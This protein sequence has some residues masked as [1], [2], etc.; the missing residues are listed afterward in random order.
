MAEPVQSITRV[1]AQ[2]E[3]GVHI[4]QCASREYGV[5][6]EPRAVCVQTCASGQATLKLVCVHGCTSIVRARTT[7][8]PP[9]VCNCFP[10]DTSACV[11]CVDHVCR[12]HPPYESR[13]S[14]V[15]SLY[16]QG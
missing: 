6:P 9:V 13:S 3:C 15:R 8:R 5:K 11:F 16:A 2:A 14:P 10:A 4:V 1:L 12:S 7:L